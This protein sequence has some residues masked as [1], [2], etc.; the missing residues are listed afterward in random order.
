MKNIKQIAII[1]IIVIL[2]IDVIVFATV[3]LRPSS[4]I[5]SGNSESA[6]TKSV[7]STIVADGTVTAQDE[8]DL[9]F[10]TGGKLVSLPFKEGDKITEGQT[11]A[12]LDTYTL[13]QELSEALNNYQTTR[14]QFDQNQ[15]NN[16]YNSITQNVQRGQDNFYGAGIPQYG[17]DNAATSYLNDVAKRIAD[18]NQNSLN[19]S[20]ISVQIA[21]YALQMATLTSP[22][23]GVVTHEDV[24][25]AG[26]NVSPTTTFSVADP[27][28]K[29][30]RANVPASDI[31]FVRVGMTAS[32]ILDGVQN[33]ITGTISNIYPT[34]ITSPDGEQVYQVDIQSDDIKNSSKLDQG[35]TAIIMTN[36][37]NVI[38]VPAWTVL[39]DK[40]VWIDN[41]GKPELKAVKVGEQH[42]DEIEITGGLSKT[43]RVITD[44]KVIPAK[45]YPIL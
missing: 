16:N 15:A 22:I 34:K 45:Q 24:T 38:L 30:F 43:D 18:E 41:N 26:Q 9:H 19:N 39:S 3:K 35:G 33:R 28:T 32:V 27:N 10:Q 13:Q 44:P 2:F 29:V 5:N 6:A 42:G 4:T 11:I 12:Q 8:A 37:Q 14:D 36:A 1:V 20:V 21:N 23:T 40:Y 17:T 25:V 7:D 31:D